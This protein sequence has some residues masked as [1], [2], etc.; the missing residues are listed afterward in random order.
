[1]TGMDAF[2]DYLVHEKRYSMHTVRAYQND[3]SRF[4]SFYESQGRDWVLLDQKDLR[5]WVVSLLDEGLSGASVRRKISSLKSFYKFMQR[6]G[7]VKS[8]PSKKLIMPKMGKKLPSFLKV[9][10]VTSLLDEIDFGPGFEACRDKLLIALFYHTGIRSAELIGL[11]DQDYD[12]YQQQIRV[13]GKRN[14]ERIIPLSRD[15]SKQLQD[16]IEVRN[17]SVSHEG[18]MSLFVTRSGKPLYARLV[19]RVV[20]NYLSRVSTLDKKS[21]HVLRHTFATHMLN[22]GADLNAVKELLG[23]ANLA[24]TQIYTHT[25]FEK[26]K[27]IYKQAHPRA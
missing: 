11:N 18:N 17:A 3:I 21:P 8:N 9:N 5:E 2:F 14:K 4:S 10:E 19:Y 1:M 23:H 27:A 13:L 16:Y 6:E 20:N 26:L 22:N 25:T 12:S 7:I 15:L 24:A